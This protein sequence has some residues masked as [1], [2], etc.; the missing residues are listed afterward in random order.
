[1]PTAS[2]IIVAK[3][4]VLELTSMKAVS[5]VMPV[6]PTTSPKTALRIGSPAATNDPKVR[7]RTTSASAMPMSSEAPPP[8][9][10]VCEPEPLA[11]TVRPASRAWSMALVSASIVAGSTSATVSTSKV[12]SMV[13]TR[14]SSDSGESAWALDFA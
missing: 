10:W 5:A 2:P 1:M 11:S 3:M 9:S 14:P 13:P 12:K 6:R 8:I 7:S 4:V